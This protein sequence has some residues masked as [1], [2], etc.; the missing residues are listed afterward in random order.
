ML[1]KIWS[2]RMK[3]GTMV[4]PALNAR[5]GELAREFEAYARLTEAPPWRIAD[6][7]ATAE[8]AFSAHAASERTATETRLRSV[9]AGFPPI[10]LPRVGELAALD[11][12]D[13]KYLLDEAVAAALLESLPRDYCVLEVAGQRVSRCRTLYLDTPD[14]AMY[15]AHHSRR[16]FRSKV[17][18]RE[19]LATGDAFFEVKTRGKRGRTTK[20]RAPVTSLVAQLP[21]EGLTTEV[22]PLSDERGAGDRL[23]PVLLN[24]FTRLTL[25]HVRERERV[26]MDVDLR[27]SDGHATLTLPGVVVVEVKQER[28]NRRSPARSSLRRMGLREERFSKYCAGVALLCDGVKCNGFR[29]ELLRLAGL[30]RSAAD[31]R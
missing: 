12:S 22:R 4:A 27:F 20:A 29:P 11:R 23:Q 1:V 28:S 19:Y 30:V 26:T 5:L 6:A 8:F 17:R 21:R 18:S 2:I 16:P 13:A 9:A 24:E 10:T 15:R 7:E 14:L 3:N 31:G 25:V